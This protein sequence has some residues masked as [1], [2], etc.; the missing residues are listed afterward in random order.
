MPYAFS[1]AKLAPHLTS[2]AL[3][4]VDPE[5]A[6]QLQARGSLLDVAASVAELEEHEVAYLQ[7]IP[8]ALRD[9]VQA[10]IVTAI[11]DGKAVH[12]QYSPGYDFEVRLWDYGQAISVH[13]AGPYGPEFPRDSFEQPG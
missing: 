5:I 1:I 9:A 3:G 4:E 12:L 8:R 6:A 2:E 7:S 11:E 13:L 10:V